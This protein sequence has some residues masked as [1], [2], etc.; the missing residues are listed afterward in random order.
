MTQ[1]SSPAITNLAYRLKLLDDAELA[2][3]LLWLAAEGRIELLAD[4]RIGFWSD[5]PEALEIDGESGT[6]VQLSRALSVDI[7][8]QGPTS[9]AAIWGAIDPLAVKAL[10]YNSC[11]NPVLVIQ[12]F[13]LMLRIDEEDGLEILPISKPRARRR[14]PA[15]LYPRLAHSRAA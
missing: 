4:G 8:W 6:R 2:T 13:T 14:G 15:R 12:E 10:D 7:A 3:R 5:A 11:G 1:S 9:G